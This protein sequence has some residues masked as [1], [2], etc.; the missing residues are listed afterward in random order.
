MSIFQIIDT[1]CISQAVLHSLRLQ[2]LKFLFEFLV[3]PN[4]IFVRFVSNRWTYLW[5]FR[6]LYWA[7]ILKLTFFAHNLLP[8]E[9][10]IS[11]MLVI[12]F[13]FFFFFFLI[14]VPLRIL[15]S[16]LQFVELIT[17]V[18]VIIYVLAP[19]MPQFFRSVSKMAIVPHEAISAGAFKVPAKRGFV[20]WIILIHFLNWYIVM[21]VSSCLRHSKDVGATLQLDVDTFGLPS[22]MS[23]LLF[24]HF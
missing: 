17:S 8:V 16:Y 10:I 22:L 12:L 11:C 20:S 23:W 9:I 21:V 13:I 18:C 6:L 24:V 3:L 1:L 19:I 5:T 2:V 7:Q 14:L 4:N 15:R